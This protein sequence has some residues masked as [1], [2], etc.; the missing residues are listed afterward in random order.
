MR[1]SVL[2]L[3]PDTSAQ[4]VLGDIVRTSGRAPML[5]GSLNEALEALRLEPTVR[6]IITSGDVGLELCRRIR[7]LREDTYRHVVALAVRGH[8]QELV[9]ALEAGADEVLARPVAPEVLLRALRAGERAVRRVARGRSLTDALRSAARAGN[10][11]LVVRSTEHVSRVFFHD[12]DVAW[13]A[14]PREPSALEAVLGG[15]LA[16]LQEEAQ[17]VIDEC[18]RTG[19]PFDEIVVALGLA[20]NDLVAARFEGWMRRGFAALLARPEV[21]TLF[22]PGRRDFAGRLRMPLEELLDEAP[23]SVVEP[24]APSLPP[25]RLARCEQ[26]GCSGCGVDVDQTIHALLA[27]ERVMGATVVH[28]VTGQAIGTG[29]VGVDHDLLAAQVR[30]L[31]S[32]PVEDPTSELSMGS[33]E[34]LYL[35]H[36]TACP[37]AIVSVVA[38]RANAP[39]GLLRLSVARIARGILPRSNACTRPPTL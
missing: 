19:A 7:A 12:G 8:R 26:T 21:E 36:A 17:A 34:E 16:D 4:A 13:L 2:I 22:I 38:S 27:L 33:G 10:G 9:D 11:E 28:T 3:E 35:S 15:S 5:V 23:P 24:R 6:S 37:S 31:R 29:G 1:R 18:R 20:S 25:P 14:A 32:S 30:L 39:V